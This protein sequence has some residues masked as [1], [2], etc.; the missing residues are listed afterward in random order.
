[1]EIA[2]LV[3]KYVEVLVWPVATVA[4]VWGLRFP[5]KRAIARLSRLETPAGTLEF[6]EEARDVR[7]DAEEI[8]MAAS[9]E[10]DE[11][12]VALDPQ[13]EGRPD[14]R[15]SD[16]REYFARQIRA[17]LRGQQLDVFAKALDGAS[18]SPVGAVMTAW[19]T[20]EALCL[21]VMRELGI[22]TTSERTSDGKVRVFTMFGA[23]RKLN[24]SEE[25]T[26]IYQ[27]LW[28]LQRVALRDPE[29]VTVSAAR[30][31]VRSCRTVADAIQEAA[32]EPLLG[33]PGPP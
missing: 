28:T 11:S 18:A 24:V 1:M 26:A 31:F 12:A 8:P 21:G 7:E 22:P 3:L 32:P 17:Q 30:D 33:T 6:A 19:T 15:E 2:E 10:S 14:S 13:P 9:T 4:L 23:L 16:L 20:L 29:S 5:I 27:R 25:T